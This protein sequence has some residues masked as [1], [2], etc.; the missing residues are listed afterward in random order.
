MTTLT[1]RY[2]WAV[3]RGVP[4]GQRKDLE[5]EI[6]ALVADA[7]EAQDAPGT[8]PD[9]GERAALIELGDPDALAA[10]YTDRT[11]FLIGP[12]VYPTW[13]RMLTLLVPLAAVVSAVASMAAAAFANESTVGSVITAGIGTAFYASIQTAFWFTLVFAVIE[14]VGGPMAASS[15]E[16]WTPDRLPDVPA[17]RSMSAVDC[18]FQAIG[19]GFTGAFLIWQQ[20]AKPFSDP[21]G[22]PYPLLDQS[23]WSFW[24]PFLLVVIGLQIVLTLIRY[25]RGRW[26]WPIAIANVVL[27]AAFA[28]PV[29]WLY[30]EQRLFEPALL[31]R[32]QELGLA[33]TLRPLVMVVI[34]GIVVVSAWQAVSG[35]VRAARE[36]RTAA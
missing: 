36:S 10:R 3:L 31:A 29:L 21:A 24:L 1:D 13:S 35:L 20:V 5:P 19:L 7:V 22:G 18:A 4:E 23:L 32:V 6:R 30:L 11:R 33:D 27:A 28:I 14:R 34:V 2:V 16:V 8:A 15:G 17:P 12:G 25:A 9:A 26:T